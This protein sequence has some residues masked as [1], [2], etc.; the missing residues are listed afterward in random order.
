MEKVHTVIDF[1]D[2]PKAGIA[3]F[4][5]RPHA[6]E[7][8]FDEAADDYSDLYALTPVSEAEFAMA[9]ELWTIWRRWEAVHAATWGRTDMDPKTYGALPEDRARHADLIKQANAF[10]KVRPA[11]SVVRSGRFAAVEDSGQSGW[12]NFQ[13][14]WLKA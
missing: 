10:K 8:I 1:H 13:V 5:G 6:Y 7:R 11:S 2:H 3:D 9:M 12:C 4:Q 14:T